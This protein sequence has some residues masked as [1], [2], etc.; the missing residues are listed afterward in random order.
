MTACTDNRR[1]QVTMSLAEHFQDFLD[2]VKVEVQLDSLPNVQ[3]VY[4]QR[5][6][7]IAPKNGQSESH[8]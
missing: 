6:G 4:K 2:A 1:V 3:V 7:H 5:K 8:S